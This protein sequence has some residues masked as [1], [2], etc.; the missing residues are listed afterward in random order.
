MRGKKEEVEREK[1]GLSSQDAVRQRKKTR[2]QAKLAAK[3]APKEGLQG[4]IDWVKSWYIFGLFSTDGPLRLLQL[5]RCPLARLSVILG[6]RDSRYF[7]TYLVG[8]YNLQICQI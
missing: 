5:V 1:R 3:E 6:R 4:T 7:S 2:F 8:R